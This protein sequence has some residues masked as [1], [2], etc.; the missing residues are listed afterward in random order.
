MLRK[1]PNKKKDGFDVGVVVNAEGQ[2]KNKGKM[3][4]IKLRRKI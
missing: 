4:D 2:G 1:G 3:I